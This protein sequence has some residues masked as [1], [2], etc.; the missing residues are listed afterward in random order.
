MRGACRRVPSLNNAPLAKVLNGIESFTPD[1][2]FILGEAPEVKGFW[3][4]CG[5]CAHG[6]SGGGGV[7]KAMAE[8]IVE[9]K[10]SLDLSSMDI[11]R[12]GGKPM[13]APEL[14]ASTRQIYHDYY[15]KICP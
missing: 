4:A 12:F 7:G 8:W 5:F 15:S 6:V 9:G 10:L 14:L 13:S 2:E 1:G 3:T 11:R